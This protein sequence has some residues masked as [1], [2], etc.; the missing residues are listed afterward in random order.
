MELFLDFEVQV[1][2]DL[3]K[4]HIEKVSDVTETLMNLDPVDR[5]RSVVIISQQVIGE[6]TSHTSFLQ[7]LGMTWLLLQGYREVFVSGVTLDEIIGSSPFFKKTS[8]E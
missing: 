3:I 2:N 5:D 6:R 1:A 7:M 8:H 4:Q